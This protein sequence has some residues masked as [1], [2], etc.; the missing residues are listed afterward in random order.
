[1]H[2]EGP[3]EGGGPVKP[4]SWGEVIGRSVTHRPSRTWGVLL[5]PELFL[6]GAWLAF[7]PMGKDSPFESKVLSKGL[8]Q[9]T[10]S[11]ISFMTL[12]PSFCL[13]EGTKILAKI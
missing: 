11:Q 1:M 10:A 2:S 4:G 12:T 13:H 8:T 3:G 7:R 9:M 6:P 5:G